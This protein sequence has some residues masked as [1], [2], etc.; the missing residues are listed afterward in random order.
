MPSDLKTQLLNCKFQG[1]KIYAQ[2]H[3]FYVGWLALGHA[4]TPLNQILKIFVIL[5]PNKLSRVGLGVGWWL[6]A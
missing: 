5:L 6:S 2:Y 1:I 3:T 4:T